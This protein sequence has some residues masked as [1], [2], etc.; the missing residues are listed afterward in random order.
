MMTILKPQDVMVML[1]LV[2]LGQRPWSYSWLATDLGMSP[3]QLHSE[4]RSYCAAESIRIITNGG[5]D[6]V[7][8]VV[9]GFP[10]FDA[11]FLSASRHR[12]SR[13]GRSLLSS[14][15]S[16]NWILYFL[17]SYL[18]DKATLAR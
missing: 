10:D 12:K 9:R 18:K 6:I 7:S 11:T 3:S 2:S 14:V 8:S 1:K 16:A 15:Q 4:V 17:G 13:S 5:T